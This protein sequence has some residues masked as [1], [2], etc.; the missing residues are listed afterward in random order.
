MRDLGTLGG[1]W[2]EAYGI[3]DAG[4]VVGYSTTA[5]GAKHAFVWTASGG[6]RDLGTLGGASS[7]ATGI[8]DVGQVVG[9]SYMAGDSAYHA[10][11]WTA[12][13]GMRDLSTL[14]GTWSEATGINDAGQ[15]AGYSY[16]ASVDYH[17]FV[18]TPGGSMRDL[19]TLGGADSL[20]TGINDAEQV[21]GYSTT[22]GGSANHATLWT[23]RR[24]VVAADRFA[25]TTTS[26]WGSAETGG[27]YSISGAASAYAVN[28]SVGTMT[29]A[30]GLSGAAVLPSTTARDVD[31]R[32]RVATNKLAAG[33][34]QVASLTVRTVSAGTEYRAQLRLNPNRT[35]QVRAAR[36]VGNVETQLGS[37]VSVPGVTHTANTF[38][39][40]RVQASGVNPTTMRLK[41][42]ANGQAEPTTW[43]LTVTDSQ[44]ALQ[45]AGTVGV[46]AFVPSAI[47]NSPV[48]FSFDDYRVTRP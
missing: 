18:W 42:W 32:V 1:A 4:Q 43:L 2:S 34:G 36:A 15:V 22:A 46:R 45:T 48:R 26:G 47:T 14:G 44:T 40:V 5:S 39:W 20:A 19:G 9:G 23:M 8:N 12:S 6:M 33:A 7:W 24:T 16:T 41:A 28:G 30:K 29:L 11:V 37:I 13:G 21:V 17:A 35:V 27:A 31:V 10:F 25:R 38:I 3:N